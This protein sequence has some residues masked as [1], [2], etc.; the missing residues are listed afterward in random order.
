MRTT[1]QIQLDVIENLK[2]VI[3]YEIKQAPECINDIVEEKLNNIQDDI[4]HQIDS[5][6][7]NATIYYYNCFDIVKELGVTNW[8]DLVDYFGGPINDICN[9]AMFALLQEIYERFE[10]DIYDSITLYYESLR[11]KEVITIEEI[12]QNGGFEFEGIWIT[13][14]NYDETG[15]FEVNPTEY[16]NIKF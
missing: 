14:Y 1:Y 8:E 12:K 16:Y 4:N 3:N 11:V 7:E 6:V 10:S 5:E 9:L 13:D 15:R 2:E